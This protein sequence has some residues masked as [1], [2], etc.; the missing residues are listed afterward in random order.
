MM[1]VIDNIQ[2]PAFHTID[3]MEKRKASSKS[4]GGKQN[5]TDVS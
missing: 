4:I 2:H 5:I 1:N 3:R